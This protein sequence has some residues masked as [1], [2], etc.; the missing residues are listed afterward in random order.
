MKNDKNNTVP[1]ALNL[2]LKCGVP[3]TLKGHK[4]L[5]EAIE[6]YADGDY[7]YSDLYRRIAENNDVK[8]KS[9]MRDISYA[10]S[11]GFE[12]TERLSELMDMP[13]PREQMHNALAISY[14]AIKLKSQQNEHNSQEKRE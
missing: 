4:Y 9:I 1:T 14:L 6:L 13:I 8:P 3:P 7:S 5:A 10:I 12:F 11:Q 2:V